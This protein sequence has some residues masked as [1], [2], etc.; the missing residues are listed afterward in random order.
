MDHAYDRFRRISRRIAAGFPSPEFYRVHA[1]TIETSRRRLYESPLLK[2]LLAWAAVHLEND[3]G[4][5]MIHCMKV[6]LDAGA[7]MLLEGH[8]AGWTQASLDRK[9]ALVQCAGLLHDIKRK[10]KNH[11]QKGAKE[12]A[13][14]LASLSFAPEDV[15]AVKRAVRNHEAFKRVE[16]FSSETDISV[17]GCLYDADKFRWGPDNFTETIWRMV[18]FYNIPF[19]VLLDRF[20]GSM[21]KLAD[22]KATFRTHFGKRYGP[23]I[24]DT[25]L[26]MGREILAEL[27]R[28]TEQIQAFS[29]RKGSPAPLFV[30]RA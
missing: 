8:R 4:H 17:S 13:R 1:R 12:A 16:T 15:R 11:A 22:I 2:D 26:A 27:E 3:L 29:K 25:G 19:S 10:E 9:V 28:K 23:A 5:G 21:K 18:S 30:G 6:T 20:P 7:L 24:V 14:I